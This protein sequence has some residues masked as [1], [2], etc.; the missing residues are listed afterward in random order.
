MTIVSSF[1]RFLQVFLLAMH[2]PTARVF[3]DLVTGW[4]FAPGRSLADRIR[5]ASIRHSASAYYRVLASGCWSLEE[6]GLRLLKLLHRS[7]DTL[8]LVG[9][10][11]FVAHKGSKVFG[12][13]MHRDGCLSTRTR[14]IKRWGH[15]WVVLSVLKES[16]RQPGRYY[17]LPVLVRLYLS[18]GTARKLGRKYRKKTELLI[19]MLRRMDAE[20]PDQKLHFLGDYGYTAPAVLAQFPRRIAVTGRAHAKARLHAP[21]PARHAGRGRPAVRGQRLDSPQEL[22]ANRAL[23]REFQVTAERSYRVRM[24]SIEGCFFQLPDR[25]VQVVVL[26]HVG[27]RREDDVFYS[28][29]VAA[30]DEQIVRWYARRW[31]IEVTFRDAKQ[32]LGLGRERNR[33]CAAAR[34]TAPVGFLLYSLIV[35]WYENV[36]T[37]AVRSLRDYPQKR[38]ASFA[39]MLAAL[40]R[41]SLR[42]HRKKYFAA[43]P[44]PADL[45]KT[46]DYLE[47]LILLAA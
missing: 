32:H 11:T 30:A 18:E 29:E 1:Q 37:A 46:L 43:S 10:D 2:E 26:K 12:T 3:S 13:G 5:A 15:A 20:L 27:Q 41:E 42:E 35:C 23:Y 8:F 28:T 24:A 7:S 47:K 21:A 17:A 39:D 38:Q 19:E 44:F 34:R 16:R 36:P 45:Q 31:S 14:T 33:T 22:L 9:D 4:L 6:V 25:L 40:R